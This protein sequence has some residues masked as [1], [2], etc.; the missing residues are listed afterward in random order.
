MNGNSAVYVQTFAC[1]E[2]PVSRDY[3]NK[4]V[5]IGKPEYPI[6]YTIQQLV[7]DSMHALMLSERVGEEVNN[8]SGVNSCGCLIFIPSPPTPP[9]MKRCIRVTL[10]EDVMTESV[11]F[12]ST[13]STTMEEGLPDDLLDDDTGLPPMLPMPQGECD[14]KVSLVTSDDDLSVVV[15]VRVSSNITMLATLCL[16]RQWKLQSYPLSNLISKCYQLSGPLS[17]NGKQIIILTGQGSCSVGYPMPC[18][19]VHKE[20]LGRPPRWIRFHLRRTAWSLPL[21]I[22]DTAIVIISQFIGKPVYLDQ[23]TRE[24]E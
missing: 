18:C 3:D 6:R 7:D 22:S 5:T 14:L 2:G 13:N 10:V 4:M 16:H 1:L 20:D 15:G 24:G 11:A 9:G 17:N 12:V 21:A 19:M 23:P 8:S